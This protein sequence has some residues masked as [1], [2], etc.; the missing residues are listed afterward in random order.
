MNLKYFFTILF[1][2]ILFTSILFCQSG[3]DLTNPVANDKS[4]LEKLQI[5]LR[6]AEETKTVDIEKAISYAREAINLANITNSIE[7]RAKANE[8]MGDLFQMNNNFQP[9]INYYLISAK[10]YKNM[11]KK[12][13]LADV[14]GKL[15]F[16]SYID[17][18]NLENA[19]QY[20][21]KALNLGIE[22]NDQDLIA[23]TYNRI[24]GIFYRQEDYDEAQYY[25]KEALSVWERL[26]SEKGIAIALNNI[27][28]IY[29][30]R[31][32]YNTALDYY[33]QSQKLNEKVNNKIL[34]ATVLEN[35]GIVKSV[36][37]QPEEA[38][39][40]FDKAYNITEEINDTERKVGL[41]LTM[42]EQ[43]LKYNNFGA[44]LRFYEN[45]YEIAMTSNHW[46]HIAEASLGLS[47]TYEKMNNFRS[48]LD[49][50][51]IYSSYNDSIN[52]RQ[53]TNRI[54]EL[55]TR[56]KNDL[57]EKELQIAKNEIALFDNE[58]KLNK[59]KFNILILSVLLVVIF[60]VLMINRYWSKV[61][62][63]RLIRQKDAELHAT[64][65]ELMEIEIQSKDNDLMNF[66]LHLVQ[67]NDMLHY[68]QQELKKLPCGTDEETTKTLSELNFT[69]QQNLSLKEDI[70]EF[71]HKLDSSYD[72]FF[73]R[74]RIKFSDLTKNEERLCAFLRLN[75]SSKEIAAINN[76]SVKA[77]EMSR[78]RLR[79]KM[80]LSKSELLPEYLQNI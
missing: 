52:Q 72:D 11:G 79:K 56:F 25:F 61:K 63:E 10:L 17:N 12:K 20:Y 34:M 8:V 16:L 54:T 47:K 38:F 9:A 6:L 36:T 37:G 76:T 21:E 53:K 39:K 35:I 23:V 75:L 7:E 62:K 49:Y 78:Y 15:G 71:Q 57:Q 41:L 22:L 55:Q 1:S 26:G 59:L 32:K 43:Y 33:K 19:M 77:A 28:E 51:K 40:Y 67:K 42:A 14:Y 58:R 69:I 74:L 13:K 29:R 24:G 80:G 48:S 60:S 30:M 45:A 70:E 4:D 50:F 64:Q 5:F 2:C 65:K 68:L 44:A 18:Y 27:G 3:T 73:R 46:P 31:K 66:A